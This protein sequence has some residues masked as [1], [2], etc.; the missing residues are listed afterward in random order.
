[1]RWGGGGE[2]PS[3]RGPLP[4]SSASVC[5]QLPHL[6]GP[7]PWHCPLLSGL[8]AP[9]RHYCHQNHQWWSAPASVPLG[10]SRARHFVQPLRRG[11]PHLRCG[12]PL[13]WK[14]VT[15]RPSAAP[16]CSRCSRSRS[17]TKP[18]RHLD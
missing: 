4:L 15:F 16:F 12:C 14:A 18:R 7:E 5:L 6:K 11:L 3:F 17:V 10:P 13:H 1:M 2:G 8:R 9:A